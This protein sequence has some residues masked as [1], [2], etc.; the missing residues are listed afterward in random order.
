LILA[1]ATLFLLPS[2]TPKFHLDVVSNPPGASVTINGKTVENQ[3]TPTQVTSGWGDQITITMDGMLSRELVVDKTMPGLSATENGRQLDITLER[4]ISITRSAEA[5]ALLKKLATNSAQLEASLDGLEL[6]A[7]HYTVE[8]GTPLHFRIQAEMPGAL[9]ILHLG[10]DDA[11]TLIYPS[12]TGKVRSLEEKSLLIGPEL[13]LVATEPLGRE[14]MV[15]VIS[16]RPLQ[17][18]NIQGLQRVGDWGRRYPFSDGD[19]PGSDLILWLVAAFE[20]SSV[21]AVIVETEVVFRVAS[22]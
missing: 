11:A 15:I 20:D 22:R 12:P 6:L 13:N 10:S 17:P 4:A 9:T 18:P 21:S 19:S 14:W 16:D 2:G 8:V 3:L 5:A 1:I 7:K